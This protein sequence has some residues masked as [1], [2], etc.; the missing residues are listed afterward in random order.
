METPALVNKSWMTNLYFY[1][2]NPI[3]RAKFTLNCLW[4]LQIYFCSSFKIF[5]NNIKN[6]LKMLLMWVD[7][8]ITDFLCSSSVNICSVYCTH[9]LFSDHFEF[10]V[11]VHNKNYDQSQK[12]NYWSYIKDKQRQWETSSFFFGF[13]FYETNYLAVCCLDG[14]SYLLRYGSYM[15][16][17]K[18][19]GRG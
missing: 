3:L 5:R 16:K 4:F 6:V 9:I 14:W 8:Q 19:L 18:F 1:L 7:S 2:I 10:H 11:H 15:Q 17:Q 12:Q 13:F